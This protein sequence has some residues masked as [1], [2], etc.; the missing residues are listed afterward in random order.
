MPLLSRSNRRPVGSR[1]PAGL[2]LASWLVAGLLATGASLAAGADEVE[3][4]LSTTP[5]IHVVSFKLSA[6]TVYVNLPDD[7]AA[8]ETFSGV[9]NPVPAGPDSKSREQQ[10]RELGTYGVELAGGRASTSKPI[11]TF[12]VPAGAPSLKVR[13]VDDH[14]GTVGEVEVPLGP[15]GTP[16]AGYT[17][18]ALGQSGAPVQVSGPFDG[19]LSN[20][21][22]RIN[23]QEADPMGESPRQIVVRGPQDGQAET[24][25]EVRERGAVVTAG[26]YRNV[27]VQLSAGATTLR[28]GQKTTLTIRVTGVEGLRETL[29]VRLTNSTPSVV[30]VEGGEE[31][32]LCV[33]PEDVGMGGSWKTERGLTGVTMGGFGIAAVVRQPGPHAESWVAI[34]GELQGELRVRLLLERAGRGARGQAI[35]PGPYGVLVR[36]AGKG[37]KV[38]LTLVRQGQEVGALDGG[39]FRRMPSSTP[40][41]REESTE[42][43]QRLRAGTGRTGF[44][45]LGF[46]NDQLFAVRDAEGERRLVLESQEQDFSVEADLAAVPEP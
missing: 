7:L 42:G 45:D 36:G 31:Q 24:P 29:P 6:G 30:R 14:E 3:S 20:S 34:P 10:A 15:G 28:S 23:G 46:E 40:C 39:V 18:P 32:T 16:P 35:A 22:V 25:V 11:R 41:D 1:G 4:K 44:T 26:V 43:A 2:R 17:V 8:G 12:L 27:N 13:L 9:V 37:G 19:D 38:R 21:S 5:G 33:R